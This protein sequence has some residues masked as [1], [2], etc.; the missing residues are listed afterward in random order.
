ML[1]NNLH[2]LPNEI[3]KVIIVV[4]FKKDSVREAIGDTH[5][6]REIVYVE[7][8]ELKGTAH[9]LS[10]CKEHLSGKFLVIMGDDIYSK[11][12][13]ERLTKEELGILVIEVQESSEVD[14]LAPIEQDESGN[15]VAVVERQRAKK[16]MLVNTGAYV[17][18]ERFFG[19]PLQLA[20]NKTEEFGLPQTLM[21][22][23]ESGIKVVLAT[24]WKKI[25]TPEDLG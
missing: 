1:E 5:D 14:F 7:Q 9:A 23:R 20:G 19:L 17:M 16:G 21:L 6:G 25:T 13:L 22:L 4:G 12:D 11:G 24:N 15:A 3:D 2:N 8:K 18:D 10:L